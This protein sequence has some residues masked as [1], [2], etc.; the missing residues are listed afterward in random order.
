MQQALRA[1]LGLTVLSFACLVAC[2]PGRPVLDGSESNDRAQGTIGGFVQMAGAQ[3]LAGRRVD[4][5]DAA[6]GARRS[7]TTSATGGFSIQVPP[8]KYRLEVELLEGE[9]L[10][11]EPG[12]IDVGPSDLDANI[13]LEVG[14]RPSPAPPGP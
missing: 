3:P 7:A 10:V 13:E 14:L 1:A 8:G 2:R 6:T 12:T 5:V 4:A 11:E 9:R